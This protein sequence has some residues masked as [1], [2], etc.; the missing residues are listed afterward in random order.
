MC[1]STMPGMADAGESEYHQG[2][3]FACVPP[4]VVPSAGE[5]S[6]RVLCESPAARPETYLACQQLGRRCSLDNI[7]DRMP[8]AVEERLESAWGPG[9]ELGI[10]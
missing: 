10:E 7:K 1:R 6:R 4:M 8:C 3:G 5:G 2:G 9:L